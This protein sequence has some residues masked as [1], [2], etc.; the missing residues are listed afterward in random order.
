MR[1]SHMVLLPK[2][3]AQIRELSWIY[4]S[5]VCRRTLVP[6]TRDGALL[7]KITDN[8]LARSLRPGTFHPSSCHVEGPSITMSVAPRDGLRHRLSTV[9]EKPTVSEHLPAD[10]DDGMKEEVVWG[11]TPSG[12]V[13]RVPTTHDVVTALLHPAHP[14]SHLDILNLALLGLQLVLFAVLPRTPRKIFYFLYFAFWRA[15]YDAGLGYVLTKQSKK[16]WIVREVQR[17]GWLDEKR[18][19]EVRNWIKKQLVGKMG[20][21]Y[22]FDELPLEYNT[23]LLFRQAVDIILINDFISFCLFT[24][25]CFRVPEGLSLFVHAL[26]WIGGCILIGF[27]LWVKSEAHY[28]VKDYGWYWGDCFFQRGNLVFDG[29]FELA[30]HPMYSV[31]K[32]YLAY[33]CQDLTAIRKGY[34][35][36]YG[37]SL[38]VGSYA[39]LFVSLA[40]HAAQ[41]AFLVLFEN[42]HIERMYGQRKPLAERVPLRRKAAR[43]NA[44]TPEPRC[45][46]RS[47]S[48]AVDVLSTP[49]ITDGE[50]GTETENETETEY[51]NSAKVLGTGT[52]S[53]IS[54][55]PVNMKQR[56]GSPTSQHDLLNRYFRQDT[57]FLHNLDIFR[58]SD[59]MLLLALFY[60]LLFAFLPPLSQGAALGLHFIHSL[61]WCIFYYVGLGLVLQGQSK[62]KF[63]VRHYMKH[64]YYPERDG[65]KGAV[66]ETFN[67]WKV[68]YNL[69][70]CMTYAS[71]FGLAWKT[72]TIP[73]DWTVGNELLRHT[74]G[75]VLIAFHV[76]ASKESFEVLGVFGWFYGDFFM[77]DF[78]SSL[79]Y[80]GIYRYLNDPE[81][82]SGAAFFG[83]AL[84]SDSKLVYVL[85]LIRHLS[86]WWF[87]RHVENPHMRKLYGDSL[88]QEAGFVKVVKNVA[89]KN[90][91]L[92]ESRAGR[93]GPG[94]RRVA[95]EVKG[96]FDKVYEETAEVLEDFL[97]KSRPRI[98]EVVQDTKILLQQSREKLVITRVANDLS[99]YAMDKYKLSIASNSAGG[100]LRFHLGEQIRVNWQAP[101]N[102]S[103]RDW[104]GIYRVGANQSKL[105]TKTSS[106]GMWVPVHDKEWDGDV[107]IGSE[108]RGK[109]GKEP[110]SGQV[111][112]KGDTLPWQVGQYEVRYHHDGKYNVLSLDG[113]LEIYVN[114]PET[115]EFSSVRSS[116]MHIVPL[117]LDSDPSLIP[118]SCRTDNSGDVSAETE[119]QDS[120]DPDDFRFWS[121]R[122]ARR[123]ARAIKQLFEVEY[124]PEVIMADANLSALAHRILASKEILEAF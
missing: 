102:H 3:S 60:P 17:L 47:L 89:S 99:S 97:A 117:C 31:G 58:A 80:S 29:V 64:Y 75:A 32:G 73:T 110:E 91:R 113:P 106:L 40:A 56:S 11:K 42:P 83:L 5:S 27:N 68:I 101:L 46:I 43:S 71:C 34:A 41:F 52:P 104:I 51:D 78:P 24:F 74:L 8:D 118:L 95:R 77:E 23:W 124:T 4:A 61:F 33:D 107:P 62:E 22:S 44:T 79:D 14:K 63:L 10:R 36:F 59:F 65:G 96:T 94:I 67:N 16:K 45:R 70:M 87:L 82:V 121:E 26:R 98:S 49:S 39:V 18:R 72:Y 25:A 81:M 88:R 86:Y 84:I 116:L 119:G 111:V 115:L 55:V 30:P 85:A 12:E 35:W 108:R 100:A 103:R 37:L 66:Q 57:I 15:A 120:R 48:D 109:E 21:D 2:P 90:A 112:F 53:N 1:T 76:W 19:P 9:A 38:I 50:T 122:Q 105:V 93:H 7:Y 114:K 92:F 54:A 28:V 13:F 69:S 20:K 123:I 6:K